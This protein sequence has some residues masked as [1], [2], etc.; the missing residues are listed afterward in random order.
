MRALGSA[1]GVPARALGISWGVP[2][3]AGQCLGVPARV[4]HYLG[5]LDWAVRARWQCQRIASLSALRPPPLA[6]RP[7]AKAQ[8]QGSGPSG[9]QGHKPRAR[10]CVRVFDI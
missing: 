8:G 2:A 3:H 10:L 5:A 6:R 1:L 4:G 9:P 7:P